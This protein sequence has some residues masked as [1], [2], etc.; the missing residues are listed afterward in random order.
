MLKRLF[1]FHHFLLIA[2]SINLSACGYE[3]LG[4]HDDT[5]QSSEIS[6]IEEGATISIGEIK[7]ASVEME[8]PFQVATIVRDEVN[9]RR[10]GTWANAGIGDYLI[11]VNIP[12]FRIANFEDN[13]YEEVL[14]SSIDISLIL[15][16]INAK[17]NETVWDSGVIFYSENYES[18]REDTAIHEVLVDTIQIA[19]ENYQGKF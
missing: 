12:S 19:F 3:I 8:I 11:N 9:L 6:L 5:I 15:T 13:N 1:S 17:T 4:L 18:P 2:L 10:I 14:I 7:Q 16:I